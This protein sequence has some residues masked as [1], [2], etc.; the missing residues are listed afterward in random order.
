MLLASQEREQYSSVENKAQQDVQLEE[1]HVAY[2]ALTQCA[3]THCTL[4]ASHC[5]LQLNRFA[6]CMTQLFKYVVQESELQS[7]VCQLEHQLQQVEAQRNTEVQELQDM[8]ASLQ[9]KEQELTM[10]VE[11][12]AA[13]QQQQDDL[14]QV[15][16]VMSMWSLMCWHLTIVTSL[17]S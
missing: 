17:F 7:R 9:Q 10:F 4:L 6:S 15:F 12:Q 1:L 13:A 11:S 16:S 2:V 8:M 14:K 3:M 5:N